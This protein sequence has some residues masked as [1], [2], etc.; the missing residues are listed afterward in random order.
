MHAW[1][2]HIALLA[3]KNGGTPLTRRM[4]ESFRPSTGG[5]DS[6][7]TI[8]ALAAV[9][10][11]GAVLF[12]VWRVAARRNPGKSQSS[13]RRLFLSLCRAQRLS[14]SETWLLWILARRQ[15]L[16]DPARL[17]VEPERFELAAL[18]DGLKGN[19]V[20][21]ERLRSR[22]FAGLTSL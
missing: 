8:A 11:V 22:L 12:F 3:V 21:I 18:D 19:A 6:A 4:G 16:A 17:F 15:K 2:N 9:L 5:A 10:A 13:P 7:K 20:R 1:I 14:W